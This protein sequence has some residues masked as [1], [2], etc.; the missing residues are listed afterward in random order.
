MS[1]VVGGWTPETAETM[2]ALYSQVVQ[3]DLD[4]VDCITAEL[5]KTVENSYRDVR[6]AFADEI[7]LICEKVGGDVWKVRDLVN[8]CPRRHM[9]L[10]GR[11]LGGHCVPKAPW[12][13][14]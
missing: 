1:R 3:V 8:N 12:P 2:V 6:I 9:H 13:G 10:P 11:G 7:A 5:A 4:P 14:F